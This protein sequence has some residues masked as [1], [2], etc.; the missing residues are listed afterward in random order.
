MEVA[1]GLVFDKRG[2]VL[3]GQRT[4]DSI[5]HGKW[6]FPGGKIRREESQQDALARE[7]REEIGINVISS[8]HCI[9]FP[10]AYRDRRVMLNFHVVVEF[11][12]KPCSCED[13]PLQWVAPEDLDDFDLLE[14]NRRIVDRL[15]A[16]E[17]P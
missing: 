17:L 3:L 12:G 11:T 9:S 16:G 7:L 5:H 15:K 1:V 8:R 4:E 6:E 10:Y 13:Q 2:Q 14:A